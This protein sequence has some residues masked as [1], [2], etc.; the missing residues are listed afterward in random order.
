MTRSSRPKLVQHPRPYP[1]RIQA[2][3][4]QKARSDD[5]LVT[6]DM[7]TNMTIKITLY[8]SALAIGVLLVGSS[9]VALAAASNGSSFLKQA[10][11]GDIAETKIGELAQQKST[12][13]D[14]KN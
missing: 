1:E 12:N 5:A 7:E 3:P 10:I 2:F 8:R 6:I 11:R 14:V 13:P 9:G 4:I